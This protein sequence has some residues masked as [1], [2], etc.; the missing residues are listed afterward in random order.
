[1]ANEKKDELRTLAKK[2]K[3]WLESGHETKVINDY[4]LNSF[5]MSEKKDRLV[6]VFDSLTD[7]N[8]NVK[9]LRFKSENKESLPTFRPGQYITLTIK[10]TSLFFSKPFVITSTPTDAVDGIYEIMVPISDDQVTKYLLNKL[11][12]R[13]VII[14]SHPSGDFYYDR[15]RDTKSV[16]AISSSEEIFPIYSMANSLTDG[17]YHYKLTIFYYGEKE[18]DLI[19]KKELEKLKEKTSY[20][21]VIYV[22]S[23]EEKEGSQKGY[24]SLNKI[25]KELENNETFFISCK[26]SNLKYFEKELEPLNLPNKFIHYFKG[27][28]TCNLKSILSFKLTIYLYNEKY[29][30]TCYNNKTILQ[31]ILELGIYI[32]SKCQNGTCG[33]CQ[34]ELLKGKVKIVND[35]RLESEKKYAFI[36]PCVTYPLSDIELIIR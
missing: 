17:S 24:V 18:K 2:R 7:I 4:G 25:K 19:L 20:L 28:I 15:I 31:S 5:S 36:H 11:K 34:S 29:E 32:P 9:L 35:N 10:I 16:I 1:M 30:T 21:K 6:L 26:E 3:E 23:N 22:L 12:P 33:L 14:S 27:P 8:E 13:D